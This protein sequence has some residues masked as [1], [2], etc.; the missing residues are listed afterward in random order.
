MTLKRTWCW[1]WSHDWRAWEE[2]S[3]LMRQ[4]KGLPPSEDDAIVGVIQ[5]KRCQRCGVARM[6]KERF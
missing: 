1:P 5:R 6:R 4:F 3:H 2:I